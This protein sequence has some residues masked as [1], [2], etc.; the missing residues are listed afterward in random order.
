MAE[1][2][3]EKVHQ[4][5]P[6]R[7]EEARKKGNIAKSQ[8]LSSALIL[9]IAASILL[10]GG[11]YGIAE[12]EPYFTEH[13]GGQAWRVT[14]PNEVVNIWVKSLWVLGMT[15]VPL[16]SLLMVA[17]TLSHVMQTGIM[18]LPDK[19]QP[20][21][22]RVNPISG[23]GRLFSWQ[24]AARLGFGL[25]KMLVVMVVAAISLWNQWDDL[26]DMVAWTVPQIAGY[27]VETILWVTLKIGMALLILALL[28]YAFQAWQT[29]DSLK[30]TDQELR[31][32]FKELQGDPQVLARRRQVQRQMA[33]SRVAT[34][35]PNADA[36]IT[37]PTELAVAIKYDPTKMRAPTVVAKGAGTMAQRIRR[38]ALE[39]HIPIIE[40]KELAQA[41]YR[42]VEVNQEIPVDQYN[43][44][45]EVLRYVY[46]LQGKPLPQMP[47][48][49][50]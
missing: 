26:I 50:A 6:H 18:F 41:L 10:F 30:M 5:T 23:F 43:A 13:L 47:Q 12:L 46:Q 31:E 11:T 3:G 8:D 42:D 36:I 35:V 34:S 24:S 49:A 44:V 22:E 1:Q 39:N 29:A 2:F 4:A 40:R 15:T 20:Q 32:E 17:A 45:A 25:F 48:R 19:L 7:L 33:Q 28:D 9:V 16:M 14:T 21:W 37:N 38:I 27:L